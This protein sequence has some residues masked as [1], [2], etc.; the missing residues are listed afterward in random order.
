[1]LLRHCRGP[2]CSSTSD[3]FLSENG[4]FRP[5][6]WSDGLQRN[7]W[8]WHNQAHML[9]VDAPAFVGFSYSNRTSD[10]YADD[11]GTGKDIRMF[12][13][14][15]FDRFPRYNETDLWLSGESYAGEAPTASVSRMFSFWTD[16]PSTV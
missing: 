8:S 6:P 12:L 2:G 1:M 4:P 7:K 5:D 13:M 15:F 9:Y 11:P 3:G 10:R 14:R 16:K